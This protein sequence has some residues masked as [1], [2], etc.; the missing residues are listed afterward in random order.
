MNCEFCKKNLSTK[1]NLNYHLKNNKS[2]LTIQQKIN[3][4]KV[5]IAL[6]NCEFCSRLFSQSNLTRHVHL[7]KS[8]PLIEKIKEKDNEIEVL[9]K[10]K[11]K[12]I[13]V[14]RKEKDK[15]IEVLRKEKDK[16]IEVLIK[17]KDIEIEVLR[18]NLE[19]V[20]LKLSHFQINNQISNYNVNQTI[21][22]FQEFKLT[23][24]D[25]KE[26]LIPMRK[27]GYVNATLLCKASGKRID[28]W[29]RLE[30][31]KKLL[32]E[33][34]NSLRFEGVKSTDCLEGKYGGT[35]IHPDLAVQLAQWISSSFALQVSRWIFENKERKG[36]EKLIEELSGRELQPRL[37]QDTKFKLKLLNKE[38]LDISIRKDGYINATQ[39]C[40]A[41]NKLFADYQKSKQTQDYLQALSSNMRIPILEL[42]DS[43]V[44][45]SHSGTYVHRK[46]AYH[47]AQW[48]SPHFAVQ[49]S[50]VLDELMLTGRVELGN[51]KTDDELEIIQEQRLSLDIQ[52]YL[53]KDVI[54]ILEFKPEK[55]Y[56]KNPE[57]LEDK[58]IH[59]FEFGVSSNIQQRQSQYGSGCRLDKVF[60]YQT[61]FLASLGESYL[62]KIVLDMKLK[63]VYKN[64]QECMFGT[65]DDLEK[66]SSIITE[67]NLKSIT[68]KD[69][70][71]ECENIEMYRIQTNKEIELSKQEKDL[72]IKKNQ[73]EMIMLLFE[74]GLLSF[75][76]LIKTLN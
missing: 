75:E 66:I 21:S 18:K 65:Y 23:L 63:L 61:G 53:G 74:K 19:F 38:I 44:G 9:R 11:D 14:L 60:V 17:E 43:K 67:H 31:T 50:N 1:S 64:K 73:Q 8:K 22:E 26:F 13:E 15:E 2:C 46:V 20:A 62:K 27:D 49:V 10:E 37:I 3:D 55:E 6:V 35:F 33:F 5:K 48:I 47:L 72:E 36:D 28:N 25:G 40:K 45:G 29:L 30:T 68:N 16:E 58:N 52:P 34:S 32:Q 54:Y 71:K 39:L 41:G 42:L 69:Y 57:L 12:E 56:L 7:C 4:D 24:S 76:Q 51:E 70:Q 59:Y